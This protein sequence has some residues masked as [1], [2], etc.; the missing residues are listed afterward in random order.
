MRAMFVTRHQAEWCEVRGGP[1]ELQCSLRCAGIILPQGRGVS[2]CKCACVC[3]RNAIGYL[4]ALSSL[5]RV[6]SSKLRT[7][8]ASASSHSA[9][10]RPPNAAQ[11]V[12][13]SCTIPATFCTLSSVAA[14]PSVC[15]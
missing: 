15:V 11:T 14:G 7:E 9:T 2:R 8:V 5:V 1:L 6:S 13:T 12:L 4:E 10:Q 3:M